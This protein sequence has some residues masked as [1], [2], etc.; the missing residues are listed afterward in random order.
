MIGKTARVAVIIY[1]PLSKARPA[2]GRHMLCA[3]AGNTRPSLSCNVSTR[4]FR[5]IRAS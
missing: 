3:I 4:A 1:P 5:M 2:S